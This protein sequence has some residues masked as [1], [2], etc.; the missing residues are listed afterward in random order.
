MPQPGGAWAQ[1]GD[2]DRGGPP[3]AWYPPAGPGGFPPAGTDSF[4]P[5]P[6]IPPAQPAPPQPSGGGQ[7]PEPRKAAGHREERARQWP[8]PGWLPLLA[9]L[10][11]QA[12]FSVRLIRADTAFEDEAAYLWAGHLEW[13]HWLHGAPVPPFSAYFSGAPFLYP[14]L[15]A[16]ADSAGGLTG[17][18]LLSLAFMLGATALLWGTASRLYGRRAG[19][20][21]AALFAAAGPT[22]HL[23]AFATYDAMSLF[24]VALAAWCITRA[25]ARS[26]ATGWMIAAG[27][28]L[29]LANMTS[30]SSVLLDPVVIL[31]AL[32]TAFPRP[33]GKLAAGRCAILLAVVAVL[34][35]A[36]LLIGSSSYAGGIER[37]TFARVAGSASWLTVLSDTWAWTGVI[38]VLAACGLVISLIARK[39][40]TENLLLA[41]LAAAALLGPLAQARLHTAASLN[42]H[43]G[44]G[45][46]FA[47]IAAGYA[48]D[49]LV[50]T[51]PAG[52]MRA[53]TCAACVIGLIFPLT[54]AASQS[55]TFSTDWPNASGFIA[56]FRPLAA[57]TGGR[58]LVEDPSVAEYYLPSGRQW[59]RWSSTRNITLPG[60]ASTGGPSASAGVTGP[61]NAGVFAEF[62][63][64]GYFSL[65]ALN[66]ADTTALDHKLAADLRQ[67][68]RYHI[69]QVIPYG[70]APGG[71]P[72]TYIIWK[73]EPRP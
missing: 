45:A 2:W 14:P 50:A 24:L 40:R 6:P 56:I 68:H 35:T 55:L 15:G 26:D 30:Y 3:D 7:Q 17:A 1:G 61:G 65:V 60:G 16:L 69:V 51:A 9:V 67:N 70:T 72:G 44:L 12:I 39:P 47:A 64:R 49:R 33:G 37:T 21:A 10:V 62:I 66:F 53:W 54:L 36:G 11:V 27:A 48:V 22:L 5:I 71:A 63:T 4:P 59:Q 38:I 58:L 29:A 18:R 19:F 42:K 13:A 20:F 28:A 46:W 57:R 25:G 34:V 32:L 31:L 52:R 43:V 41:L 8:M 73:Y 23:G